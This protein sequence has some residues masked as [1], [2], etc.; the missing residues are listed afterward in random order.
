MSSYKLSDIN[1][2]TGH[3]WTDFRTNSRKES[4]I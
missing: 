4:S 2:S 3:H 1:H